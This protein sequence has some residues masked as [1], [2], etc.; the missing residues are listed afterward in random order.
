MSNHY[1]SAAAQKTAAETGIREAIVAIIAGAVAGNRFSCSLVVNTWPED[2]IAAEIAELQTAG[3]T[4]S[5]S[6][7]SN[8]L[9]ISWGGRFPS[10]I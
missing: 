10:E 4:T 1:V 3:Y 7:G 2:L 9:K 8:V 6:P 5:L